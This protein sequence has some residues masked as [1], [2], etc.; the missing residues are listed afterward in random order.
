M[1]PGSETEA[2]GGGHS[3]F[4]VAQRVAIER[5]RL[6]REAGL[7][8]PRAAH[9]SRPAERP[10]TRDERHRVTLLFGGLTARTD[11]L[12]RAATENLGYRVAVIPTPTKA[13]FQTGKEYGNNGQCNPT[14][15]TVGALVNYL[16]RLRDEDGMRTADIVRDYV[17]VTAGA[18]GPCRFGMYEAEFRLAL[19]NS[20]FDGL[21]VVLF[22]QKGGLKQS[23]EDFGLELNIDFALALLNALV[24]ADVLNELACRLRPYAVEAGRTDAVFEDV[25]RRLEA[26]L[27]ARAETDR[28]PPWW[29]RALARAL[30]PLGRPGDVA[31]ILGQLTTR[32][33]TDA[34]AECRHVIDREVAVDFTRVKP[35]CKITG[36]FWAQTTEGDGNYRM[37]RF[38]EAQGAE[39]LLEPITTWVNYMIAQEVAKRRD[40]KGLA[41]RGRAGRV[42]AELAF[43][44]DRV[45]FGLATRLLNREYDRVRRAL[46]GST[47]RQLCQ[48]ELQRLGHPYYNRK[49]GGGEGHLEVAKNIYYGTRGLAHMVMSLKPFGC[50]PSSQSDGAQAAVLAHY[51][52]LNFI[53]IE[54]SG[55][56]DVN[57][58]SRALMALGDAR[59]KAKAEFEAALAAC[60]MDL[61]TLRARCAARP[62]CR[63]PLQPLPPAGPG[64]TATATRFLRRLARERR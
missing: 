24:M 36:E 50:M 57:A 14:Y 55:E 35:V 6:E 21:R 56:G 61:E 16:R 30:A 59:A 13:D 49:T 4:E 1:A 19:R 62:E 44:R 47:H 39:V 11:R 40:R 58:H 25:T 64:T 41:A 3:D 31:K 45:R 46:G 54:T 27:T 42:R 8:A 29:A 34:L 18:C 51:P 53:P 7:D 10:F 22:Q 23:D 33:Y 12:I 20:G 48:L 28:R 63:R 37:F 32:F 17:F 9:F 26:R 2:A 52:D 60:G 43:L 38:L 5:A 15:F